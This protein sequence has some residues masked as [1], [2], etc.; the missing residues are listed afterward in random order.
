MFF[1]MCATAVVTD[2]NSDDNHFS[3]YIFIKTYRTGKEGCR[4][5]GIYVGVELEGYRKRRDSGR[6][7]DWRDSGLKGFRTGGI[8]EVRVQIRVSHHF[9]WKRNESENERSE[10][11]KKRLVSLVSL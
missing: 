4:K 9:A 2:D 11:A 6:I 1:F 5:E 3:R 7:R 8:Q 10:M